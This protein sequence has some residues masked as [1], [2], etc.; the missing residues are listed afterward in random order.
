MLGLLD[1]VRV[2]EL[3]HRLAGSFCA[4][5]LADQ[6]AETLKIESP[7]R[8]DPSR[9]E[10]PFLGDR[11]TADNSSLFLAYNTNKRGITLDVGSA[12]GRA[13]LQRLLVDQDILIESYQPGEMAAM[14]LSYETLHE[15]NPK[16]IVVSITP[17]GQ[18]GPYRDYQGTDLIA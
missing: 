3:S 5:L 14:G 15:I 2:I 16:L 10:P 17:F 8:G 12:S 6:G 11:P 13:L 18:T 1:D 7:G 4:K 9:Y